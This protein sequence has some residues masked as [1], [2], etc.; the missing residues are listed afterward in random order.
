MAVTR[1]QSPSILRVVTRSDRPQVSFTHTP[2]T[3]LYKLLCVSPQPPSP[4]QPVLQCDLELTTANRSFEQ[5][6]VLVCFI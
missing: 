2:A 3:T 1:G 6:L 5:Q 4:K